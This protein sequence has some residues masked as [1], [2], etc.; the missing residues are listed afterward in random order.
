MKSTKAEQDHKY[1]YIQIEKCAEYVIH[2]Y[3]GGQ[4]GIGNRCGN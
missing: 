3:A 2:N 1:T 4:G